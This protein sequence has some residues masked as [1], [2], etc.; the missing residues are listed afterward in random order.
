MAVSSTAQQLLSAVVSQHP[1]SALPSAAD[2]GGEQQEDVLSSR[3]ES[4]RGGQQ[5]DAA[6]L[7]AGFAVSFSA[8]PQLHFCC[9]EADSAI[10]FSTL[11]TL[12]Q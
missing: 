4:V 3:A 2:V 12:N 6:G 9:D 10:V 8:G 1:G 7:S 5:E 11:S